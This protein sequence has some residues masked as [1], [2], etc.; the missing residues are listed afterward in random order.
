MFFPIPKSFP[1]TLALSK[2]AHSEPGRPGRGTGLCGSPG[3][4]SGSSLPWVAP[5]A[6]LLTASL[7]P[8]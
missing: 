3:G 6:M 1:G 2:H 8:L 4:G 7:S 5:R